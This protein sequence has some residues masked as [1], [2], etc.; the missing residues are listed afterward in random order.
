MTPMNAPTAMKA[1][2]P[3]EISPAYPVTKFSPRVA[4][5]KIGAG[6]RMPL[7]QYSF[8]TRGRSRAAVGSPSQAKRRPGHGQ[9]R[10][11][12]AS[13]LVSIADRN[14]LRSYPLD[15]LLA[16]DAVRAHGQER[17]R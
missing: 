11:T 15:D 2:W 16:E 14:R 10:A 4:S 6:I 9:C 13:E 17:E 7:S 8:A 12:A 5:E 1:A 3:S